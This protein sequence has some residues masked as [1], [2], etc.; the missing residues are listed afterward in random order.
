M[1]APVHNVSFDIFLQ[2]K[3]VKV[4]STRR[5]LEMLK[6]E[7]L[8]SPVKVGPSQSSE[9]SEDFKTVM[10][11]KKRSMPPPAMTLASAGPSARRLVMAAPTT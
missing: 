4:T 10:A 3:V 2:D 7:K 1:D 5:K 11:M 6:D 8:V 9:L